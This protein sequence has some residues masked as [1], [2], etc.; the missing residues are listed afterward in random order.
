MAKKK[1]VPLKNEKILSID[2]LYA[3]LQAIEDAV[4]SISQKSEESLENNHDHSNQECAVDGEQL[5]KSVAVAMDNYLKAP[6]DK[7]T[8]DGE[9]STAKQVE[10]VLEEY[11]K[12]LL[13]LQ[14]ERQ[15]SLG[16]NSKTQPSPIHEGFVA[17]SGITKPEK[18]TR[19]KDLLGYWLFRLPRYQIRTL[20]ASRYFRWWLCTILFCIW[21]TSIFLTCIIAYD[22]AKLRPV[23]EKYVLL[24]EYARPNQQWAEKADYIEYLY[25][26]KEEHQK[27]IEMLWEQRHKRLNR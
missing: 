20:F 6:Q 24:R 26:D 11:K 15:T 8:V 27:D 23:L 13:Q 14:K 22:N 3:R 10:E 5:G 18:P 19:R 4:K 1:P 21:L 12:A 9:K 17:L 2:D 16:D 25:S 7:N